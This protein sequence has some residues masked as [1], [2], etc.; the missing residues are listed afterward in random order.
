M[1]LDS[2][3]QLS[4][5]T[6]TNTWAYQ[7]KTEDVTFSMWDGSWLMTTETIALA[8]KHILHFP[9]ATAAY[10]HLLAAAS[11]VL[12]SPFLASKGLSP[13]QLPS[14]LH[15][16]TAHWQS[17]C[18]SGAFWQVCPRPYLICMLQCASIFF[19]SKHRHKLINS[20]LGSRWTCRLHPIWPEI[21]R[22]CA[23]RVPHASS[24]ES[25][26]GMYP[27][28]VALTAALHDLQDIDSKIIESKAAHQ[29]SNKWRP[30]ADWWVS[31]RS[32]TFVH[33]CSEIWCSFITLHMLSTPCC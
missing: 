15:V 16:P 12:H 21:A 24:A 26:N 29:H 18:P 5:H 13:P 33:K 31:V 14:E 23:V 17:G 22:H 10:L 3:L 4:S 27:C 2:S 6:K 1:V 20:R 28:V 30:L 25:T 9:S 8:L 19:N 32:C 11:N 7:S